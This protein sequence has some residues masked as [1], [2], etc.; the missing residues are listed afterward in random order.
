[1]HLQCSLNNACLWSDL[2]CGELGWLYIAGLVKHY[3]KEWENKAD[4]ATWLFV[5]LHFSFKTLEW[6]LYAAA[7][8][9]HQKSSCPWSLWLGSQSLVMCV[10]NARVVFFCFDQLF[11]IRVYWSISVFKEDMW[12]FDPW[13]CRRREFR[14]WCFFSLCPSGEEGAVPLHLY[15]FAVVKES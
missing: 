2:C 8:K 12:I 13:R 9:E 14:A 5:T 11:G 15:C 3:G 10:L 6:S 4:T 1:M 7:V